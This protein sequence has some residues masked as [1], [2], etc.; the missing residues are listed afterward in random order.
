MV[1]TIGPIGEQALLMLY[2]LL[3]IVFIKN[4]IYAK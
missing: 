1:P 3:E 4:N 2:L